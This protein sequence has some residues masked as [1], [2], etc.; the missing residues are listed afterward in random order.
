MRAITQS[1]KGEN[2][3]L[4][5][6]NKL[7]VTFDFQ[8]GNYNFP[9]KNR[10]QAWL[11]YLESSIDILCRLFESG[12]KLYGRPDECW[13]HRC[14][15]I[16]FLL[17]YFWIIN[18]FR[19]RFAWNWGGKQQ[20]PNSIFCHLFSL[21]MDM[22]NLTM[23]LNSCCFNKSIFLLCFFSSPEMF[24]YPPDLILEVPLCHPQ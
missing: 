9:T 7:T 18:A 17:N 13:N 4:L 23:K 16:Q 24:E 14:K 11:S 8:I 10:W 15:R 2:D 19:F 1:G 12:W 21:Q 3:L 5:M 20:E 22:S 6:C